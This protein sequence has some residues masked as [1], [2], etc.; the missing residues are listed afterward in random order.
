MDWSFFTSSFFRTVSV[1][2]GIVISS[3]LHIRRTKAV[4]RSQVF[5]IITMYT[6]GIT[7]FVGFTS[8]I[9]H[10]FFSDAV[11]QSIGWPA[12]NPFQK[13]VA[14][15]NLAVGVIGF[16]G[17]WR[18]DFWAP[19]V[20]V[21]LILGWNAGIVHIIDILQHQNFAVGN[22]GPILYADFLW[23]IILGAMLWLTNREQGKSPDGYVRQSPQV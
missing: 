20:I 2:L 15:A 17:F 23:P 7:G 3:W 16:L 12:G 1:L 11:A 4:T 6:F 18:R 22:A 19:Y 21:R 14:G 5:E 13:E 8:F 9:A 10:F